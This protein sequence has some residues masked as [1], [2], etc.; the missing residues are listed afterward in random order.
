M[1]SIS[2]CPDVALAA[3][4]WNSWRSSS[5]AG[6]IGLRIEQFANLYP[7]DLSLLVR[8]RRPG[9]PIVDL[10]AGEGKAEAGNTN[11]VR[12]S[13]PLGMWRSYFVFSS[14]PP[15]RKDAGPLRS[16]EASY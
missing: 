11:R 12:K 14:T 10:G 1:R 13:V 9:E 3:K 7:I 2:A 4:F 15:S 16:S 5:C 8:D 6:V